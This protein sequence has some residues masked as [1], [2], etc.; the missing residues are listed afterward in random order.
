MIPKKE[1]VE[2]LHKTLVVDAEKFGYRINS[3]ANF[4]K[5]LVQA[6]LINQNRYGYMSCPCRLATAN[7]E[8]DLDIICPCDYRD[9][10]ISN[11]GACYC[12]LY[13]SE[14][15]FNGK[16]ETVPVP[17]RRGKNHNLHIK[18]T[19]VEPL[20][21]VDVKK[22]A[23]LVK[24][25]YPIWRCKICGYLCARETPPETCPICKAK[26]ERFEHFL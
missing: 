8:K 4:A 17:E 14:D 23:N 9:D 24:L 6:L 16:K 13:V 10:D 22:V 7:K 12:A 19:S 2:E 18:H 1:D 3:D 25:P 15:V 21:T 5:D 26:K 20:R 11:Y